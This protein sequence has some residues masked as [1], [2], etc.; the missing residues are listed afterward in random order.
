MKIDILNEPA[1]PAN[2]PRNRWNII[3]ALIIAGWLICALAGAQTNTLA[4]WQGELRNAAG[5]PIAGAKISLAGSAKS[6]EAITGADG[7]FR[8][9]ALPPGQYR[10]TVETS[11]TKVK[12]AQPV[13]VGVATPPVLLTQIGRAHV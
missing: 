8:V 13:E 4:I 9:A 11:G 12:F 3:S 1:N 2:S 7:G 5:A 6:V 10:L